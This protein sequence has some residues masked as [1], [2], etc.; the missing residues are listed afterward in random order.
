M[1]SSLKLQHRS[2]LTPL[3]QI[4]TILAIM[5]VCHSQA[6]QKPT[7]LCHNEV[8]TC[9]RERINSFPLEKKWP[10]FPVDGSWKKSCFTAAASAHAERV[11]VCLIPFAYCPQQLSG[12]LRLE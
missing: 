12:I 4:L 8:K 5:L 11:Y 3:I 9:I 1:F 10:M 6:E 2:F 7:S